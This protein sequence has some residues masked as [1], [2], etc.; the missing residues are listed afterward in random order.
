MLKN[1]DCY[2]RLKINCTNILLSLDQCLED[3]G[4]TSAKISNRVVSIPCSSQTDSGSTPLYFDLLIFSQVTTSGF[5]VT[6]SSG[7][8]ALIIYK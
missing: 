3:L 6:F 5:P 2:S 1:Y 4:L 8:A 7:F